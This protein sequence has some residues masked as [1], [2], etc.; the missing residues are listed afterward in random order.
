MQFPLFKTWRNVTIA[1]LHLLLSSSLVCAESARER[2]S[3]SVTAS[4]E[5]QLY[6]KATILGSG[7]HWTVVPKKSI[8]NLPYDLA[9][10]ILPSPKGKYLAFHTFLTRNSSWLQAY[11]VSQDC[12]KGNKRVDKHSLN[13]L[14]SSNKIVVITY[15]K[16][17]IS[18]H[19]NAYPV[20]DASLP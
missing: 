2:A 18:L 3:D 15:K 4:E 13:N 19:K 20:E 16:V 5:N 1:A 12:A 14:L 8:I 9:A 7:Q 11:P 17:P 6:S 10:R